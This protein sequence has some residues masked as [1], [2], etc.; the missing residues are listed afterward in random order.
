MLCK[1]KSELTWEGGGE[2][3]SLSHVKALGRLPTIKL[4]HGRKLYDSKK[5]AGETL[6]THQSELTQKAG[7]LPLCPNVT[8]LV[9]LPSINCHMGESHDSEGETLVKHKS[10]LIREREPLSVSHL[11]TL[12]QLAVTRE[13]V[14]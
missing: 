13:N 1:H 12:G 6:C 2:G 14:K 5:Q 10:E 4:S 3:S 8:A 7:T 9:Q 11:T